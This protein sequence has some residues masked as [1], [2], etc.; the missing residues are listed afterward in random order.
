MQKHL[1][2]YLLSVYDV[3]PGCKREGLESVL[4]HFHKYETLIK[5]RTYKHNL[6]SERDVDNLWI[7]HFVPSLKPLELGL[8]GESALCI[9]AGS[10]AGFPGLP[11]KIFR[12]DIRMHLCDSNRK[13]ALFLKEVINE[14]GLQNIEVFNTRLE[15]I[16]SKYDVLVSRAMGKPKDTYKTIMNTLNEGGKALIWTAKSI[17]EDFPGYCVSSHDIENSGKLICL[18]RNKH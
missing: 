12:P 7:K 6:V 15:N 2:N 9:D 16:E 3:C 8:I 10:G 1:Y 11:L 14:L 17:S 4:N 18:T 13:R 5:H